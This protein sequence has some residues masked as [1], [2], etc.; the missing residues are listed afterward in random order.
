MDGLLF[1]SCAESCVIKCCP[2]AQGPV[3]HFFLRVCNVPCSAPIVG[4]LGRVGSLLVFSR[5]LQLPW[6]GTH[7]QTVCVAERG[8]LLLALTG[9]CLAGQTANIVEDEESRAMARL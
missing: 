1:P 7:M 5:C 9:V 8:S 6:L 4:G 2:R 3:A